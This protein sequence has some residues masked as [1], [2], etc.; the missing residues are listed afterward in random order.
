M[1]TILAQKIVT[2]RKEHSC[3]GCAL[4]YPPGTKMN[5]VTTAD[6][7]VETVY[8]CPTCQEYWDGAGG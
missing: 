4:T 5:A 1:S 6:G 2:T 3:W 8:W 7:G